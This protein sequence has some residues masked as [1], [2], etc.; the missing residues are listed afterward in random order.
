VG[1][2]TRTA[3]GLTCADD[4]KERV[5]MDNDVSGKMEL[6]AGSLQH[7]PIVGIDP[8]G[9]GTKFGLVALDLPGHIPFGEKD[10]DDRHK[11]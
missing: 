10:E 11:Q 6:K 4:Q 3:E 9:S 1:T 7:Q 8:D 5:K 2:R